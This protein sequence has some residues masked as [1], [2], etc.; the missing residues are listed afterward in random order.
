MKQKPIIGTVYKTANGMKIQKLKLGAIGFQQKSL[1]PFR[2]VEVVGCG[3]IFSS[4]F[5]FPAK[6]PKGSVL[7]QYDDGTIW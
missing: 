1:K 3:S 4:K 2:R 5:W 6:P 7:F